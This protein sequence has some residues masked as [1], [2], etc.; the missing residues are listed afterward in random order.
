MSL[1]DTDTVPRP[2]GQT[3]V[4]ILNVV[5]SPGIFAKICLGSADHL[6]VLDVVSGLMPRADQSAG[7]DRSA[8]QVCAQMSTPLG[9]DLGCCDAESGDGAGNLGDAG[10]GAGGRNGAVTPASGGVRLL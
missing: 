10:G 9:Q 5:P 8:R 3:F 1:P 7:L 6:S 2:R 4:S